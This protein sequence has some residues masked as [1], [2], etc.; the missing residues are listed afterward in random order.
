MDQPTQELQLGRLARCA[1]QF[2]GRRLRAALERAGLMTIEVRRL[3]WEA[4]HRVDATVL[5]AHVTDLPRVV[6]RER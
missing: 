5:G 4:P 3:G 6:V 2:E 1:V